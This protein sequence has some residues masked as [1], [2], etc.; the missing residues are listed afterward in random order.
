MEDDEN[1]ANLFAEMIEMS[2]GADVTIVG[3]IAEALLQAKSGDWDYATLDGNLNKDDISSNDGRTIVKILSNREIPVIGISG[4][5]YLPNEFWQGKN[6]FIRKVAKMK[7]IIA[8]VNKAK[9]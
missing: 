3:K 5:Q 7:Y 4:H 8:A 9:S 2:F 6:T 1:L